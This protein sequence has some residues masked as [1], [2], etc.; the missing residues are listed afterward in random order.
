ML[1]LRDNIPTRRFPVV[2]VAIIAIC[3]VVFFGL[4]GAH[5]NGSGFA[6]KDSTTVEYA[7]IPYELTHM[8]KECELSDSGQVLCEGKQG[9]T[10]EAQDQPTVWLTV[11]FSMFMHGGLLHIAGNMLFLWIFGNNVED[12]MGRPRFVIFYLLGGLAATLL[13]TAVNSD[14][15][16]PNLG[17][18]GAIA[19]VL[20]GYAILYPRARVITL[21]FIVFF[22]TVLELP[23]LLVLGG[24]FVLQLLDAGA[25]S[26]AG[27]VGGVAYFAHIGGFLFG[28]AAIKLFARDVKENYVEPRLPVY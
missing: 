16:V 7:Y 10:G 28:M 21:I 11:L 22:V 20:G 6:V 13:Q 17:A 8:G 2:T 3:V 24:W 25:S 4:Q 5:W 9:V 23:A 14:S 27:D 15:T 19:A 18:S 12:S 1:P 26:G